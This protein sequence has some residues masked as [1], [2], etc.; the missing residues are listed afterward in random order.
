MGCSG[1]AG[2]R[3]GCGQLQLR[4]RYDLGHDDFVGVDPQHIADRQ[5]AAEGGGGARY[6]GVAED[7]GDRPAKR[8]LPSPY[9]IVTWN[10]SARSSG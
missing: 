6:R 9:G 5:F 3:E 8:L 2:P 1:E 10:P 4:L 7:D